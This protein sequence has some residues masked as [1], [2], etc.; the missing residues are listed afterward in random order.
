MSTMTGSGAS[1]VEVHHPV[2]QQSLTVRS[3]RDLE[4]IERELDALGKA[5]STLDI[6]ADEIRNIKARVKNRPRYIKVN[7]ELLA[8]T[9]KF[10]SES[11]FGK[12]T[13]ANWKLPQPLPVKAIVGLAEKVNGK[14]TDEIHLMSVIVR[15]A[16]WY[17]T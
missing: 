11:N 14:Y 12:V 17:V 13:T 7:P 2:Q 16:K 4:M 9:I 3:T 6:D 8:V 10:L 1:I 15:Y 5:L